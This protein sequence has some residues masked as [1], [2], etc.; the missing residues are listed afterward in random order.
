[1]VESS[2]IKKVYVA[3]K[4]QS[5]AYNLMVSTSANELQVHGGHYTFQMGL[6]NKEDYKSM[7]GK[8]TSVVE[9]FNQDGDMH[10]LSTKEKWLRGYAAYINRV[11][12][13]PG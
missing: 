11:T 9:M 13:I 10:L 7:G 5:D 8:K 1:M 2:G 3:K 12:E 4:Y 6:P